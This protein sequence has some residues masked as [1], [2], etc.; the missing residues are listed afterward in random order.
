MALGRKPSCHL[1]PRRYRFASRWEAAPVGF[2]PSF[3]GAAA[4]AG[5]VGRPRR[6]LPAVLGGD[7]G[8]AAPAPLPAG[9]VTAEG[10]VHLP[11]GRRFF[12]KSARRCNFSFSASAACPYPFMSSAKMILNR[13]LLPSRVPVF[14][15]QPLLTAIL[16]WWQEPSFLPSVAKTVLRPRSVPS[17]L[18]PAPACSAGHRR[19]LFI[20]PR[21]LQRGGGERGGPTSCAQPRATCAGA[22]VS[23]PPA[24]AEPRGGL[25]A[26]PGSRQE[27]GAGGRSG[28]ARHGTRGR[29]LLAGRARWCFAARPWRVEARGGRW[30]T[31]VPSRFLR[32]LHPTASSQ[33]A[34]LK[35]GSSRARKATNRSAGPGD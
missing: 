28:A 20:Q 27:N 11:D 14:A 31:G 32:C 29:E 33:M 2:S 7:C 1:P 6:A 8:L 18:P 34:S 5:C 15:S 3:G 25:W 21:L 17:P 10:F 12:C 30:R 19:R 13:S 24:P 9:A 26:E 4:P 35:P 16:G 23:L 22:A